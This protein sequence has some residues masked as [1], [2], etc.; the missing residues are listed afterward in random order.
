MN[1]LLRIFISIVGMIIIVIFSMNSILFITHPSLSYGTEGMFHISIIFM[2][3]AL[4]ILFFLTKLNDRYVIDSSETD[5]S[6]ISLILK[7]DLVILNFISISILIFYFSA[8]QIESSMPIFAIIVAS[9]LIAILW[10]VFISWIHQKKERSMSM[11]LSNYVSN[12]VFSS[13]TVYL[14]IELFLYFN[15]N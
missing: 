4:G 15:L 9:C 2:L 10:I 1:R 8:N 6:L 3:F 5:Q 11:F 12:I 14:F 7:H 13:V